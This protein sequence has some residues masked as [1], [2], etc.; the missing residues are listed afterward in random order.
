MNRGL[1]RKLLRLSPAEW[2]ELAWAQ[3]AL[4]RAWFAVRT[5]PEG[6]LLVPV[7]SSSEPAAQRAAVTAAAAR[8]ALALA[9]VAAYGVFRPTCLVRAIALQSMLRSRGFTG[10]S[11]R[12]GVRWQEGRFLAHAWVEYGGEVLADPRVG[13]FDE[14][15]R[16]EVVKR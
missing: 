14:L 6:R 1:L 12:V 10:S 13:A 7:P 11:V 4:I 2:R 15:A 9:R 5:R 3:G 8:L 16:L